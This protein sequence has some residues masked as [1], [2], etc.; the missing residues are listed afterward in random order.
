MVCDDGSVRRRHA[1]CFELGDRL[2]ERGVE[3]GWLHFA[4]VGNWLLG[5]TTAIIENMD[6]WTT[7]NQEHGYHIN[8]MGF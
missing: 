1:G 6:K 2:A 7:E 5:L 4:G 8:G 3:C